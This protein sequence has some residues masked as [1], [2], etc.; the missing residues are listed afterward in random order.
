MVKKGQCSLN[1][2]FTTVLQADDGP[3]NAK[4]GVIRNETELKR[5]LPHHAPALRPTVNFKKEQLIF[6][7]IGLR[8]SCG[9]ESQINAVSH[10]GD[11]GIVL[12]SLT[13]VSYREHF[14]PGSVDFEETNPTRPIDVIKTKKLDG[15][16]VFVNEKDEKAAR[17]SSLA[18][19]E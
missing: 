4:N 15:E 2:V 12:P 13:V 19:D 5:A 18:R 3:A 11:R 6:V 16:T 9:H 14:D 10:H 1:V 8:D 17:R 7:A